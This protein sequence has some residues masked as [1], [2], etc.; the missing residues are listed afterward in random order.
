MGWPCSAQDS[1]GKQNIVQANTQGVK[2]RHPLQNLFDDA[3]RVI[4]WEVPHVRNSV[5][6]LPSCH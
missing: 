6:E 1:Q 2:V 3:S 4:L 5:Q